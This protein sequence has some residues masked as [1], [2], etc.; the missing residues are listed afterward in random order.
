MRAEVQR[1]RAVTAAAKGAVLNELG[2][3]VKDGEVRKIGLTWNSS[4]VLGPLAGACAGVMDVKPASSGQFIGSAITGYVPRVGT[5]FV[6]FADG[7]RYET[8]L[9]QG[10][11]AQMRKVDEQIALFNRMADAAR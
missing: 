6:A 2:V 10:S 8:A 4:R 1:S 11:P 3:R 5:I 7:T 9:R